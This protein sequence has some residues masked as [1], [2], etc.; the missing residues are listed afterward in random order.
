MSTIE[1]AERVKLTSSTATRMSSSSIP[2]ATMRDRRIPEESAFG[3]K[4]SATLEVV[5]LAQTLWWILAGCGPRVLR[6]SHGTDWGPCTAMGPCTYQGSSDLE[7]FDGDQYS[8]V[9]LAL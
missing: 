3:P 4:S 1:V 9:A 6:K 8:S 5:V 7:A 2:A